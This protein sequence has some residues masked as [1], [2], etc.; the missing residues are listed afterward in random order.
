MSL[1]QIVYDKLHDH[2]F[3]ESNHKPG[4]Y[5]KKLDDT[6]TLYADTRKGVVQFYGFINNTERL[7]DPVIKR[8][9][10]RLS[11]ELTAIGMAPLESFET[12]YSSKEKEPAGQISLHC[13]DCYSVAYVSCPHCHGQVCKV[14]G[15][16]II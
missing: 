14:C 7:P 11:L 8:H 6:A 12:G 16:K 10:Q 4:L 13:E 9:T 5:F 15:G 3:T 2:G 1:E